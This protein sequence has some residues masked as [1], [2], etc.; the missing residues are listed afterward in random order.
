MSRRLTEKELL[1]E[2]KQIEAAKKNP[3][4]FG[5]LY[6][7]YYRQIF[8]FVFKRTGEE[9]V[10]ADITA[11]VFLKAM[12]KIQKYV[13]KGVPFSAWLYRIA[14]NEANQYFRNQKKQRVISMDK[15]DIERVMKEA[16]DSPGEED[17][18]E[19]YQE[20]LIETLNEMK[21]KEVEIIELRFFEKR[22]YKEVA[23]ILG[24]TETNAKVRVYRILDRLKKRL[25]KKLGATI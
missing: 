10:A 17:H 23:D 19:M 14:S 3:A 1:E 12:L 20:V 13:Y 18:M 25:G 9:E 22:P 5:V 11:Q 6:N 16:D 2:L 24:I 15:S 7:K 21:P 8:L 4:R